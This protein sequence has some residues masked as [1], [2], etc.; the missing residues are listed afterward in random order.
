M[1]MAGK[2]LEEEGRKLIERMGLPCVTS[3][4][5]VS[6]QQID[7]SRAVSVGEHLEF[8]YLIPHDQICLIGEITSRSHP[9]EVRKKYDKFRRQ[10]D[11]FITSMNKNKFDVLDIPQNLRPLFS[12][13]TMF[14]GFFISTRFQIDDLNLANV[15]G[16]AVYY[17]S[18]WNM[19]R[20]FVDCIYEYAK[21]PFLEKF[22][23]D[24][25]E[26][27]SAEL[28]TAEEKIT[29]EK[30]YRETGRVV[31]AGTGAADVYV[32]QVSPQK[33]LPIAK[34]FRRDD[35]PN[36]DSSGPGRAYQRALELSKL[37]SI[38]SIID[39]KP[40]FMFPNSIIGVLSADTSYSEQDESLDIP[41]KYGSLVIVD[42]QHR[43]FS[44]AGPSSSSLSA[45]S[46]T[47][48]IISDEVRRKARI[49]VMAIKFE[50][51]N[52]D[53]AVKYAAKTFI[54]IN[55]NHTKI[56]QSH[57]YMIEYDVLGLT[58]GPALAAKVILNCNLSQG[59]SQGLFKTNRMSTG[60]LS[61]VTIIEE[62][63]QILEIEGRISKCAGSLEGQGYES[64]FGAQ[65]STLELPEV[66]ISKATGAMKR[67]FN[68]LRHIF[69]KDWP[70]DS[71]VTSSLSRTKFFAALIR[72]FGTMLKEGKD[73]QGV[74][75][76]LKNINKN[77]LKVRDMTSYD[78]VLFSEDTP[79]I[80]PTWRD[81]I[82]D[83]HKFLNQ[84]RFKPWKL[85]KDT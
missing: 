54:E 2:K 57:L 52:G 5:N 7:S 15:S 35:L 56:P 73:W 85:S 13:I 59:A 43:L 39:G 38:R 28:G 31:S 82:N 48:S 37:H 6:L 67:Y 18:D 29:I 80:V 69:N 70:S 78:G 42:G 41:K 3:S 25:R 74:E 19:L 71:K 12:K 64:L 32:F 50:N 75:D 16:I 76:A 72:L 36:L 10:Y 61:V 22:D 66:L 34:V 58:T 9:V 27:Q 68:I 45:E 40:D 44:Y 11:F 4:G 23:L 26:M 30:P 33:L 63:G 20:H 14:R 46:P 8:D 1:P 21:Y 17:K 62:L 49:L 77:V 83:L 81:T 60:R 53:D 84:N 24:I 55:R 65:L 51:D 79:E 47:D